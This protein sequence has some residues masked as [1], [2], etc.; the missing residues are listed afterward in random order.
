MT[1]SMKNIA[2]GAFILVAILALVWFTFPRLSKAAS[3]QGAVYTAA[4]TFDGIVVSLSAPGANAT[5]SSILNTTGNDLYVTGEKVECENVGTAKTAYT[6]TGL[7]AQTVTIAT[8]SAATPAT[9]S[10][11][12]TLP[13]MTIATTTTQ[14]GISSS[15]Q[16]TPGN[17]L[18]SNVW[19]AGSYMTF[20]VNA[21]STATC[22]LGVDV[23]GS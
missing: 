22:T 19:A 23:V 2:V 11:T 12:N 9:N 8:S 1:L 16:G 17:G 3:P 14:F 20:F 15:T 10:N 5:S 13:I 18:I 6:G 21:T 4:G 7:A